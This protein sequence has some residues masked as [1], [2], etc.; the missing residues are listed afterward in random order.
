MF[1][2]IVP[3][4]FSLLIISETALGDNQADVVI[5]GST[6][7]GCLAAVAAAREGSSVILLEPTDHV[8][9][10]NTGGLSLSDSFGCLRKSTLGGLWREWHQ[11]IID[12]YRERGIELRY[13]LDDKDGTR[14]TWEPHV[15]MRV[16]RKMLDEA[17]VTLLTG[18]YLNSVT[19]EG[20]RITSLVTKN[21]TFTAKVFIDA[22]YE[23]D[24]LAAAGVSWTIGREASEQFDEPHAGVRYPKQVMQIN[25]FDEAGRPLPLITTTK[26]LP[27]GAGDDSLQVFSF[28]LV[29]TRDPENRV[30]MPEPA[31]FDP[32]RWELLRRYV[33]SGG[34]SFGFDLYGLPGGKFDG[35]DSIGMQFSLGFV[36]GA[37]E[38]CNANEAKRAE[39]W[40]A[41]RQYSLELFHFLTT[42]PSV[43]ENLRKKYVG[44]GLCKDEFPNNGHFS[45]AL[46][47]RQGRRMQGDYFMT[48]NDISEN[49]EKG[50]SVGI[51]SFPIDAHDVTRVAENGGGVLTEGKVLVWDEDQKGR[52]KH[53]KPFEVPYSAMVPR[54][55]ECDNLIVPVALS[56]THVVICSI[57]VEPTWMV[58][59]Q[60]A[61]I[62]ASMSAKEDVAVQKLPYEKLRDRL[63]AHGQILK[64]PAQAKSKHE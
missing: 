13:S 14:W 57:R 42:D 48:E 43:P 30:P 26:K 52:P 6:P 18:R 19:K 12:D 64:L 49:P 55:K 15:A 45:S 38:W 4:I 54:A 9:G 51:S 58:L 2:R 60:S 8:G 31:N 33:K 5:F 63:L 59:G 40:E 28:R 56:C 46:Y 7:A 21:G 20:P 37:Q 22:T 27:E 53:G 29:L 17:G 47:V 11:R 10:M 3:L 50:D 23:G 61:G 25:G 34:R 32:S 1:P 44:L 39:I 24:L 41:H 35:N 16:T 36:G 62:A